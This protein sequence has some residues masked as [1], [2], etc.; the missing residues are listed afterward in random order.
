M[1]N[2]FEICPKLKP[3]AYESHAQMLLCFAITHF[4]KS[5]TLDLNP[6]TRAE[7]AF[8][9]VSIVLFD[10][11]LVSLLWGRRRRGELVVGDIRGSI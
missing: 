10:Q 6:W 8:C 5:N 3:N 7:T 9:A 4:P 11:E 2:L 1:L